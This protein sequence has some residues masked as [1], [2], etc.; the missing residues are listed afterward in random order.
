MVYYVDS[1]K[2]AGGD[3]IDFVRRADN[4]IRRWRGGSPPAA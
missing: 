2:P 4:H 1:I 3:V